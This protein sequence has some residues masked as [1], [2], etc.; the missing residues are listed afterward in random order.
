MMDKVFRKCQ[1]DKSS[2]MSCP[3]DL[4]GHC[5]LL[6]L[7][8]QAVMSG[9]AV[10]GKLG[11]GPCVTFTCTLTLSALPG[12]WHSEKRDW[13]WQRALNIQQA[14]NTLCCIISINYPS[15]PPTQ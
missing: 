15:L 9:P 10:G 2:E 12:N 1:E 4:E 5:L 7:Q 8:D 14:L 3:S 11:P 13:G 6:M